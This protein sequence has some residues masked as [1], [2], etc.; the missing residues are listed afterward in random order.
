MS[1][2]PNEKHL[3][4]ESFVGENQPDIN[5]SI[6]S[7]TNSIEEVEIDSEKIDNLIEGSDISEEEKVVFRKELSGLESKT[8]SFKKRFLKRLDKV[9]DV[10]ITPIAKGVESYSRNFG[11]NKKKI[12]GVNFILKSLDIENREEIKGEFYKKIKENDLY[13]INIPEFPL[14]EKG[15]EI[16]SFFKKENIQYFYDVEDVIKNANFMYKLNKKGVSLQMISCLRLD[17]IPDFNELILEHKDLITKL[18]L[19]DKTNFKHN[20][21]NVPYYEIKNLEIEKINLIIENPFLHISFRESYHLQ[22]DRINNFLTEENLKKIK[23][24]IGSE[25]INITLSDLFIFVEQIFE[26]PKGVQDVCNF[27]YHKNGQHI[28]YILKKYVGDFFEMLKNLNDHEIKILNRLIKEVNISMWQKDSLVEYLKLNENIFDRCDQL[29]IHLD[30]F[31]RLNLLTEISNMSDSEFDL[32]K[33]IYNFSGKNENKAIERFKNLNNLIDLNKFIK[34]IYLLESVDETGNINY[35]LDNTVQIES[36]M[37]FLDT[38]EKEKDIDLIDFIKLTFGDYVFKQCITNKWRMNLVMSGFY[39]DG[40]YN[41]TPI[42]NDFEVCSNIFQNYE[43]INKY[44]KIKNSEFSN[45]HIFEIYNNIMLSNSDIF[46]KEN[47]FPLTDDMKCRVMENFINFPSVEILN[48]FA[49]F[50]K[51]YLSFS[52][53]RQFSLNQLFDKLILIHPLELIE[54]KDF[55]FS[56][57][58]LRYVEVF[59]KVKDSPSRELKNLFAEIIPLLV[60]YDSIEKINEVLAKIEQVFL[61]NNIP[62][63]GKQY[64]IFEII[65][66]DSRLQY[67]LSRSKVESLKKLNSPVKQRLT[68]FKDLMR[69]HI[70][71]ADS[72]LEQ[73]L[74]VLSE[75]RVVLDKF[76][77]GESLSETEKKSLKLFIKKINILTGHIGKESIVTGDDMSDEEMGQEIKML[78]DSLGVEEGAGIIEKFE[79]FF[80]KRI[81]IETVEDAIKKMRQ[82]KI[83]ANN[84]NLEG[85]KEGKV[86]LKNGDLVKGVS[87]NYLDTYLDKGVYAPEFIGAES[88]NAKSSSKASDSTPF[89][90][91]LIII[92]NDKTNLEDNLPGYGDINLIL[93][94]KPQFEQDGLDIFKT[95]VISENHYGIRTGF[96]STQ[97]DAIC[98]RPDGIRDSGIDKV[99][100]FIAKKGFYI[101]ICDTKGK[102]IFTKEDYDEYRKIFSGIKRYEG[103]QIQISKEWKTDKVSDEIKSIAQTQENI[104]NMEQ[105]RDKVQ[106]KI[107]SILTE[108]GIKLHKG[109]YDDSLLGAIM[110]DTGSTGRGSA[111]DEKFDFDFVVKLDDTDWDK[112]QGIINK[113]KEIFPVKDSYT[114]HEMIMFRSQEIEID[115]IKMDI[116]IGF[117]KKSDSEDFAAHD[118]LKEK[119]KSIEQ[120]YGKQAL[121]DTLTNIR[122]AKKKLKEAECYKKGNKG[123]EQQGGLGGIGVEYWIIQN[124]GDAVNAF[125]NLAEVSFDN[126]QLVP[127][128]EFKTRFKIFSAGQNLRGYDKVENFAFNMSESGYQKM[129]ELAKSFV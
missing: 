105:V 102:I 62:M 46:L 55:P 15:L 122:Y 78:S 26:L 45:H 88:V 123:G 80:L 57:E 120:T 118:A 59:K 114:D 52:K 65:Y 30:D 106:E 101:P 34:I 25:N 66:G 2:I 33:M 119:Y 68:I 103:E 82:M 10:V 127:F 72:N 22:T 109:E 19:L 36:M 31:Y 5:E 99:K 42:L 94:N 23:D 79:K 104:S 96:G 38:L 6:E 95:G 54:S 112:V 60:K 53:D 13:G 67:G 116:D 3:N 87:S 8:S 14:N 43:K 61:T 4:I 11:E 7:A 113:I 110:V 85:I 111:L 93:K 51:D 37:Y 48:N 74:V 84:R 40:T 21:K 1:E 100:Y 35:Y 64:K 50:E 121:L 77:D 75:G 124:G 91:D 117:N 107:K 90:T 115:G 63:V 83:N 27:I 128:Q 108:S 18:I 92:E 76:E 12:D 41:I 56:E 71:S 29:S 126:G 17:R 58:Q 32:F 89:D 47:S 129:A 28:N 69:A 49:L 9:V 81:G 70:A 125:R 20:L 16:I 24:F 44:L 73:Y 86:T 39:E 97:I 98:V